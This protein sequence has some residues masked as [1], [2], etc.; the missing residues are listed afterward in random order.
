MSEAK[1]QTPVKNGSGVA[2]RIIA[3][4]IA[5]VCVGAFFLP[6][7]FF[8]D[9]F[10]GKSL[11]LQEFQLFEV[12]KHLKDAPYKLFTLIPTFTTTKSILGVVAGLLP[13]ALTLALVIAFFIA[14]VSIFLG[15][16]AA[17]PLFVATIIFTWGAA[18]Y[19]IGVLSITCYL[20]MAITFDIASIALA[21]FGTVAFVALMVVKLGVKTTILN[22]ARFLLTLCF[23]A[24]L[25]LSLAL[26]FTLV[27]GLLSKNKAFDIIPV[28][29]V[30]LAI[31]NLFM[32][33]V[34]ASAKKA[35]AFDFISSILEFL[36]SSTLLFISILSYIL[37]PALLILCDAARI[38]AMVL[39]ILTFAN[40]MVDRK[41]KAV[42]AV[43][44]AYKAAARK[45]K[46]ATKTTATESAAPAE[47]ET[48]A[49]PETDYF[50]GKLVDDFIETLNVAER[51]EF[52]SLYLV[53]K[54]DMPE[55][56]EYKVG[57]DNQAFFD[58]VFIMLGDYRDKI[59][60]E[61]LGKMYD[62]CYAEEQETSE[63]SEAPQTENA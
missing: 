28:V 2:Y 41:K 47:N 3:A 51:N 21:A 48:P 22:S 15:K 31:V 8:V 23:T 13:Y 46:A 16:K 40:L 9:H 37:N 50:E 29:I 56:P 61:L 27:R 32:A 52:A 39:F 7:T 33:S 35:F 58:M 44:A 43:R 45:K 5:A 19:A 14:V 25:I 49:T 62:F 54:A 60:D 17:K 30:G 6:T 57:G 63:V 55:I 34:R 10:F 59:S 1:K 20:P 53:N 26:E 18:L 24:C 12:A 42:A 11:A 36:V 38:I 4:L